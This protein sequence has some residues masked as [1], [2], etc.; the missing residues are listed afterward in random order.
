MQADVREILKANKI[1]YDYRSINMNKGSRTGTGN[2]GI[3]R[4]YE[5]ASYLLGK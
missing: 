4:D 3:N 5:F 1:K 2:F